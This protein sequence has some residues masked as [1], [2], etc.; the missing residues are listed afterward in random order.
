MLNQGRIQNFGK[1]G[2]VARVQ[3]TVNY[4]NVFAVFIKFGSSTHLLNWAV[5]MD[6]IFFQLDMKKGPQTIWEL[7]PT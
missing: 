3:A 6:P 5:D 7:C 2:G 4:Q 1:G